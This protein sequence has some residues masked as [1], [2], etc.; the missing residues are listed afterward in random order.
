MNDNRSLIIIKVSK[1]MAPFIFLYGLYVVLYGHLSPGGGFPG[2]VIIAASFILILLARG[3]RAALKKLPYGV[4][5]EL[6]AIGALMFLTVAML[7][8]IFSGLFFANF[9]QQ[10]LPGETRRWFNA[11]TI[12]INNIA[13]GIKVCGAIF[14]ILFFLS[15]L[16]ISGEGGIDF[17]SIE[18]K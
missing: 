15:V 18:R 7:G 5:K 10:Y 16:R 2:G 11:G 17:R 9:L 14:V 13:I 1:W 3:R 8:F 4:A 6:D 12:V